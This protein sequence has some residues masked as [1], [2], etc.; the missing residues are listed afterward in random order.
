MKS[1]SSSVMTDVVGSRR[2]YHPIIQA[3]SEWITHAESFCDSLNDYYTVNAF[4]MLITK[5][6]I[7]LCFTF[8][9][10]G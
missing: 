2:H 4:R 7:L 6:M 8:I 5:N 10:T 9:Y 3:L 1:R